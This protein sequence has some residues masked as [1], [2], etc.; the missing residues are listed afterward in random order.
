[1]AQSV[2]KRLAEL[3]LDSRQGVGSGRFLPLNI[4]DF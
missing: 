4:W 1:L 2:G 3:F